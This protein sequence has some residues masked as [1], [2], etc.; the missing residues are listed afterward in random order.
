MAPRFR[1]TSRQKLS[2]CVFCICACVCVCIY[3]CHTANM[4]FRFPLWTQGQT[5][6][7]GKITAHRRRYGSIVKCCSP[8]LHRGCLNLLGK[9]S[10]SSFSKSV[11]F[12]FVAFFCVLKK[13]RV[14]S[15]LPFLTKAHLDGQL[16]LAGCLHQM[17]AHLHHPL[18]MFTGQHGLP[19]GLCRR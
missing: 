15:S 3:V 18:F 4:W 14:I 7:K 16:L 6:G 5:H 1:F 17:P 11:W 2:A 12:F 13:A 8:L 10:L 19:E 9:T